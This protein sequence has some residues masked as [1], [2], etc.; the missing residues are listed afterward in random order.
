MK[1]IFKELKKPWLGKFAGITIIPYVFWY[2]KNKSE[3]QIKILRNHELIHGAQVNDEIDLWRKR[4]KIKFLGTMV[5][6]VVWYSKYIGWWIKNVLSG[7]FSTKG[8]SSMQAY[9]DIPYEKEAYANEKK[10][11]YLDKRKPFAYKNYIEK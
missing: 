8:K 5:G 7:Y 11:T 6:W 3:H 4:L 10:L 1:I 9:K 2:I